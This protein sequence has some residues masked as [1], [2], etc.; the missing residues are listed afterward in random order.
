MKKPQ[1]N[2]PA[3]QRHIC[4]ALGAFGLVFALS[5]C[6]VVPGRPYHPYRYGYYY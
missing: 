2:R 1:K 4:M 3:W 6:I 5:G